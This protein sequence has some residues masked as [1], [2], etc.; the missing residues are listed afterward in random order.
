MFVVFHRKLEF[1]HIPLF[2][3]NFF[4]LIL[5]TIS[6]SLCFKMVFVFVFLFFKMENIGIDE[7]RI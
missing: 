5:R 6:G 3:N 2:M 7:T 1:L 4:F